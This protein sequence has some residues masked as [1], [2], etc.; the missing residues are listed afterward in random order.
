VNQTK[1]DVPL[2]PNNNNK[3]QLNDNHRNNLLNIIT[4]DE[5]MKPS[6]Q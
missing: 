4:K 2:Q 6:R 5:W 1:V 3:Y